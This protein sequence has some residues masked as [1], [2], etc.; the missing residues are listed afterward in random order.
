MTTKY[1]V[2]AERHF[3]DHLACKKSALERKTKDSSGVW[4][5]EAF[6]MLVSELDDVRWAMRKASPAGIGEYATAFGQMTAYL[7]EGSSA[8]L[9]I[10]IRNQVVRDIQI[11]D[12]NYSAMLRFSPFLFSISERYATDQARQGIIYLLSKLR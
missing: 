6:A 7:L 11:F 4:R 2:S 1:E 12:Q 3:T 10:G 5:S 9:V 8:A